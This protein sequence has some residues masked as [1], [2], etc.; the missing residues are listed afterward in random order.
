MK[1]IMTILLVCLFMVL[2]INSEALASS[3]SFDVSMNDK[4]VKVYDVDLLLNNNKVVSE[5]KPYIHNN[6][7][8][9]PVR[10]VAE[11]FNS[12][13]GWI[14]ESKSVTI[15][16]GNDLIVISI[17]KKEAVK[18]GEIITLN[19]DSI[20][21]LVGYPGSGEHKTMI[22]LRVVSELLGYEV[23]WN[24][25][26]RQASIYEPQAQRPKGISINDI[27]KINGTS[28]NEQIVLKADGEL[29]YTSNFE[30]EKNS[31][32]MTFSNATF[33][34]K[35]KESGTIDLN[36][37][38]VKSIVYSSDFSNN[39]SEIKIQLNRLAEPK[40]KN[41]SDSKEI[42]ISFTNQVTA[43]RPIK[44]QAQDAIVVEGV[45]SSEYNIIKLNNPF[46]Y[47]IDIQ[48]ATFLSN[49]DMEQ[50]DISMGF[51]SSVRAS[52][53]NPDQNYKSID[54]I[55]RIVLDSKNGITDGEVKILTDKDDLII[56]PKPSTATSITTPDN[57]NSYNVPKNPETDKVDEKDAF[58]SVKKEDVPERKPRIKPNSKS[59]VKIVIDA[60]HGGRDPGAVSNGV[61]EKKL[62]IDVAKRTERLLKQAGYSVIMTRDDDYAL[63][64]YN[65]PKLANEENAHVFLS[66]HFN[67]SPNS[68]ANG[69]ETLYAP[70]DLTSVKYDAQYP[71]TEKIH[72]ELIKETG[73]FNRGIKQRA[74]LIVL[75][76]TEMPAVLVELGFLSNSDD[77]KI[78]QTDAYKEA[79]AKAMT[80]GIIKHIQET[81]NL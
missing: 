66:I 41:N 70:R 26:R 32:T 28:K 1:K 13:V 80:N 47:V 45:K 21:R 50:Y 54:N 73:M 3:P 37:N 56:I 6:R 61:Q 52:Q 19:D 63:N 53:F 20:P 24:Q 36:G 31:L 15:S 8:F 39:T 23:Q 42:N 7:T 33:N 64:I 11:Y 67:S 10:V 30:E 74:D 76:H 49:K 75:K 46:R 43:V 44:Y 34:I 59:D 29:R 51:V 27:I 81:Y 79:C 18:N 9:V 40:L 5:F 72:K 60:G 58:D 12:Q 22:P 71:L 17:D 62:N 4:S 2:G 78:V 38:V 55:V 25:E 14:K 65:R 69:I 68:G 77:L 35:D 16:K 57:E 48:D